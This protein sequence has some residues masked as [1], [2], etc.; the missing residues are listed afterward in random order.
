MQPSTSP[1]QSAA[2]IDDDALRVLSVP[3]Q[4]EQFRP[5]RNLATTDARTQWLLP[6]WFLHPGPIYPTA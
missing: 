5:R 3:H 2:R 1:G 4:P 6:Q